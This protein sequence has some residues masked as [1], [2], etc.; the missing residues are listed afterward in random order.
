M[1]VDPIS[2]AIAT[3]ASIIGGRK[4]RSQAN[5]AA[6][7]ERALMES[8]IAQAEAAYGPA[9]TEAAIQKAIEDIAREAAIQRTDIERSLYGRGVGERTIGPLERLAS[10][11]LKQRLAARRDI[12]AAYPKALLEAK[13]G[14][15][16]QMGS[17]AERTGSEAAG[18]TMLPFQ[19]YSGYHGLKSQQSLTDF[20]K[21]AYKTIRSSPE[22]GL[23]ITFI[24]AG[25]GAGF[26]IGYYYGQQHPAGSG[27]MLSG[28]F[29]A[30]WGNLASQA[31]RGRGLSTY[32]R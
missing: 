21:D 22:S 7:Q 15:M 18:A 14:I 5:E 17:Y 2:A 6:R 13:M 8:I 24:G 32:S 29:P 20:F 27:G 23:P 1:G 28:G 31:Y 3:G 19:L 30:G 12:T 25:D 11:A 16:P 4:A 26:P 10:E 9:A